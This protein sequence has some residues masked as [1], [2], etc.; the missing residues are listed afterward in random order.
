MRNAVQLGFQL[1]LFFE[2]I[3]DFIMTTYNSNSVPKGL[4]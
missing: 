1:M 3:L 2:R 4:S